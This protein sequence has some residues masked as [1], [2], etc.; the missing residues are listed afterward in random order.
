MATATNTNI[1]QFPEPTADWSS[2]PTRWRLQRGNTTIINRP[3]ANSVDAPLDGANIQ[4]AA[5]EI[6]IE[7][8]AGEWEAAGA[9]NMLDYYLDNIDLTVHL[10]DGNTEITGGAYA[11]Q[12]I[13]SG[14]WTT[15]Q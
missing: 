15:A 13:S 6:D 9:L 4:F 12:T 11:A 8:P 14:D 2:A 5:G 1:V 3:L 7:L 10:Y